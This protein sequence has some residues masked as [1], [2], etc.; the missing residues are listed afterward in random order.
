MARFIDPTF[1][2][3]VIAKDLFINLNFP[4]F[5]FLFSFI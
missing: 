3:D 4:N 5:W 2:I 1:E